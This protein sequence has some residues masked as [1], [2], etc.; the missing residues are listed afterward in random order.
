MNNKKNKVG[1]SPL[2]DDLYMARQLPIS[3]VLK[4][5]GR[6][7][8]VVIITLILCSVFFLSLYNVDKGTVILNAVSKKVPFPAIRIGTEM[9]SINTY[10]T[11]LDGW[12]R[13]YIEKGLDQE[14]FQE[15]VKVRAKD[16]LKR[17]MVAKIIMKERKIELEE[18]T[19]REVYNNFLRQFKSEAHLIEAIDRKFGWS[20]SEFNTFIVEPLA[21]IRILDNESKTWRQEQE[22]SR[23]ALENLH[24]K[25]FDNPEVFTELAQEFSMSLSA[26]DGGELGLRPINEYPK[27]A[28]D[29]LI[30]LKQGELTQIIELNDRFV[31]YQQIEKED[32]QTGIWINARELSIDKKGIFEIIK[33]RQEQLEI[34][35]YLK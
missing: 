3:K 15:E 35:N 16:K 8:L 34:K 18:E 9:I 10:N 33:E 30:A 11:I 2:R 21:R 14:D 6:T 13:L 29:I 27:E 12:S 25:I 22:R 24:I 4:W 1:P 5:L 19:T 20:M 32:K 23:A 7:F 31:A 28:R 26:Q 17:D